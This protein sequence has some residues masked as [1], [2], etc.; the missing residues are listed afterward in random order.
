MQLLI[1]HEIITMS[2][3]NIIL[4]YMYYILKLYKQIFTI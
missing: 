2:G 4:F 3:K 1:L